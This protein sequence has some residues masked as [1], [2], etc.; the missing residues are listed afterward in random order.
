M[1]ED[2]L[3][4]LVPSIYHVGS[5]IQLRSRSWLQCISVHWAPAGSGSCYSLSSPPQTFVLQTLSTPHSKSEI[6]LP[7]LTVTPRSQLAPVLFS[8]HCGEF[9]P[10]DSSSGPSSALFPKFHVIWQPDCF[11]VVLWKVS[12]YLQRACLLFKGKDTERGFRR[13]TPS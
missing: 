11:P 5:G 10:S 4:E 1:S 13:H 8:L 6:W 12:R 7:L 9:S 3:Q 2:K